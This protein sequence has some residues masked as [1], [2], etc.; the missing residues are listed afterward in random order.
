MDDS[1]V[2]DELRGLVPPSPT[3]GKRVEVGVAAEFVESEE[4]KGTGKAPVAY[5]VPY[6]VFIKVVFL[7]LPVRPLGAVVGFSLPY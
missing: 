1:E 3:F 2:V 6:S 4:S 7:R 5:P